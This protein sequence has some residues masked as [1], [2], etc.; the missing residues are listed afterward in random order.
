MSDSA[1]LMRGNWNSR[2]LA[3]SMSSHMELPGP[4][5]LNHAASASSHTISDGCGVDSVV[6]DLLPMG[7]YST[8]GVS[9]EVVVPPVIVSATADGVFDCLGSSCYWC[10]L[11]SSSPLLLPPPSP[12]QRKRLGKLSRAFSTL[13]LNASRSYARAASSSV[14]KVPSQRRVRFFGRRIST[15]HFP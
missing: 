4:Q 3:P 15:T 6:P 7:L 8:D 14:S 12:L 2:L 9:A 11:D 5:V 1:M 10:C 13:S